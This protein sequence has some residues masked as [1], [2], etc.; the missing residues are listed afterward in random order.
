MKMAKSRLSL[1][2]GLTLSLVLSVLLAVPAVAQVAK[3]G[4]DVL[5]SLAFSHEKLDAA[6][7]SDLLDNVRAVTSKSLQN[8]WEA[9]RIGVGPVAEWQ[10][11]IDKRSG[12]VS[13]AEGGNVAWIPGHGNGMLLKDLGGYLKAKPA[14]DLDVMDAIA[15]DFLPRVQS[16]MGVDASQLVLNRARSG[17]PAGYLWFVDYDV[18]RE[19]MPVEGARVVFR[20][21]NGNL[22]QFGS[23]NLPA[24]GAKVP[25]T[26]LTARQAVAAVAQYIGG[27]QAGDTFRDGGSLHLVPAGVPNAKFAE[28]YEIGHGRALVKVWQVVFHRAGVMGNWA[29]R[30]DA[31]T[32]EVLE[33][34]DINKYAQATGGTYLNSPATGAEVV[35]PMPYANRLLRRLRQ[36][37]RPL[38]LRRR[39]DHLDPR[40]PVRQDHRH[41]RR[42]FAV[43]PM[44]P[45]T[46]P[47]APRPA[48]TASRRGTAA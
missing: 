13:F 47:S 32:G 44:A 38:H 1:V 31:A 19:G 30:V 25:P 37:G 26:R 14:V 4:N 43:A 5:S 10:A 20:V 18:V 27:F 35:R 34:A 33:L 9:F 16:L 41:L 7:E 3:Q 42:H 12:L 45:A 15:R 46:S 17:Q 23:E 29:A 36:L 40:R 22:I 6:E 2:A 39:G 8:G 48:P 28:G 21:N 11:S 24:P